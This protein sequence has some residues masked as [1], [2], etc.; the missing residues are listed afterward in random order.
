MFA[1][2]MPKLA[3]CTA[4]FPMSAAMPGAPLS[5][6]ETSGVTP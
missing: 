6:L 1:G 4:S 2:L 5:P 3:I